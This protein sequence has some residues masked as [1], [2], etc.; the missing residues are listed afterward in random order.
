[1]SQA[2][3]CNSGLSCASRRPALPKQVSRRPL[4]KQPFRQSFSAVKPRVPRATE[5]ATTDIEQEPS[6]SNGDTP[7]QVLSALERAKQALTSDNVDSETLASCLGE[8]EGELAELRAAVDS[9]ELRAA[10]QESA[11]Q[12]SKDQLLRLTADFDNFRRRTASEKDAL[13]DSVRGDVVAQLLPLV[14]NFELARTSVK[15][16]SEQE[17]K[18]VNNYQN[19]YKQMVDIMRGLGVEAVPTIGSLFDPSI[20]DAIMRQ[21]NTE[22]PDGTVLVEYR[23]GFR[24]GDKLI[25]PAMVQVSYND[26]AATGSAA[27]SSEE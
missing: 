5:E 8:I 16:E 6:S 19:L 13:S 23:K 18:I 4:S 14:D 7:S 2:L 26:N 24:I 11:V 17:L 3:R 12:T 10:A 21:E 15:A 27:S 20:H 9:A 25:R 22:V 1:M